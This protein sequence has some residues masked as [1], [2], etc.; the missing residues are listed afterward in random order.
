M[1]KREIAGC[2]PQPLPPGIWPTAPAAPS[3]PASAPVVA[4]LKERERPPV[5]KGKLPASVAVIR[6]VVLIDEKS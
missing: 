6:D 3:P 4:P 1:Q 2:P 5:P